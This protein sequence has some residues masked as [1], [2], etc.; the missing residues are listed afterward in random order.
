MNY[1]VVIPAAGQ[2]KR[3]KAD[4]NKQLL[5]LDGVPLIVRTLQVFEKDDWCNGI[6]IVGNQIELIELK[7]LVSE[8]KLMK[9]LDIV[10]GGKE[11]QNSVYEGVKAIKEEILVLIHDGARPFV[12]L[13]SIHQLVLQADECGAA[14]LA[15]PL[16]DTIK[17]IEANKVVKTVDRSSLWAVQT[18][19]AFHLSIL[20][21]AHETAEKLGYIGT[22]DASLV[23]SIGKQVAVVE[24]SYLNIKLTTPEDMLFANSIIRQIEERELDV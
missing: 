23:E 10:V 7:R 22:D 2:G 19:Q 3:M 9:V 18:P 20:V 8:Y 14:V 16:K 11:R 24:G 15:V 4:R 17:Q 12:S 6:I 5:L 21:Q 13:D 1:K